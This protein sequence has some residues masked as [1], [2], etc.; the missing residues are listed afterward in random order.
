MSADKYCDSAVKN[1]K[2]AL[3]KKG[4]RLPGRCF[5]TFVKW[6]LPKI[7]STAELKAGGV[8]WYQKLIGM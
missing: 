3:A 8:Q 5:H 1:V 4:L 2:D 6:V 7:D